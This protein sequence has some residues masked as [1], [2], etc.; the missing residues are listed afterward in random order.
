MSGEIGFNTEGT[1]AAQRAQR[2]QSKAIS[3]LK[4]ELNRS[5]PIVLNLLCYTLKPNML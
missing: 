5:V 2:A 1:E 3:D 4:F